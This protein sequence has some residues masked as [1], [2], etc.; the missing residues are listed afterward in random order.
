MQP[1]LCTFKEFILFKNVSQRKHSFND[2]IHI[3]KT[4]I[5]Q[6]SDDFKNFGILF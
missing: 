3:P 5:K 2:G 6:Q 1:T 4:V